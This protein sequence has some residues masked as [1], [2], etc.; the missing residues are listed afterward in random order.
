MECTDNDDVML[1]NQ[2]TMTKSNSITEHPESSRS[3][4]NSDDETQK[5][6]TLSKS[7]SLHSVQKSPEKLCE[8]CLTTLTTKEFKQHLCQNETIPCEY[9]TD[10]IFITTFELRKHLSNA[11]ENL[12]FYKCT[13]CTLAFPM[14]RL[15]EIHENIKKCHLDD[16]SSDSSDF[17][18]SPMENC[19]YI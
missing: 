7:K 12:T 6:R 16:E 5:S 15:L 1:E 4:L 10:E 8:I 17:D 13:K 11:H 18:E 2:E 19:E 9:C 14:R 3:C